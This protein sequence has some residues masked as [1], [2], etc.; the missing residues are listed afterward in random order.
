MLEPPESCLVTQIQNRFVPVFDSCSSHAPGYADLLDY[1]ILKIR[2][3]IWRQIEALELMGTNFVDEK[4]EL[5]RA[6]QIWRSA[7]EMRFRDPTDQYPKVSPDQYP[8]VSPD[9]DPKV[10]H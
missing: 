3:P 8:K 1:L 2:P 9:Q 6:A 5:T 10:S 7:M 4:H